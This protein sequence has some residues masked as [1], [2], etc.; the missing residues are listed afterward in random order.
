MMPF[1]GL[2]RK[3]H[4]RNIQAIISRDKPGKG[5]IARFVGPG[6]FAFAGLRVG[7]LDSRAGNRDSS[8][9]TH[10]PRHR[11]TPWW[12]TWAHKRFEL[13]SPQATSVTTALAQLVKF[14]NTL[15]S[16]TPLNYRAYKESLRLSTMQGYR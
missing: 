11:S 14:V 16:V 15:A 13:S 2:T 10:V 7:K 5:I 9:A 4:Q 12:A 6:F 3:T 8:G 1:L